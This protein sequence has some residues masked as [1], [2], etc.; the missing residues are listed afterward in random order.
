MSE[1]CSLNNFSDVYAWLNVFFFLIEIKDGS[2][3]VIGPIIVVHLTC[4]L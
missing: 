2:V 1:V 4:N 3:L